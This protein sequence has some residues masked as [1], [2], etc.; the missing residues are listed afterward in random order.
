MLGHIYIKKNL[1]KKKKK[2]RASIMKS[3]PRNQ[4][5]ASGFKP[6]MMRN[7]RGPQLEH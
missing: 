6:Q 1:K 5:P 4:G 7:E 2:E 3:T